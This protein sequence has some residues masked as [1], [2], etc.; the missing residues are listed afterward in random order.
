MHLG[1]ER[2]KLQSWKRARTLP[3]SCPTPN[4]LCGERETAGK[5]RPSWIPRTVPT[6]HRKAPKQLQE[7][8]RYP[9]GGEL[10]Q[11]ARNR[12]CGE[13][14]NFQHFYSSWLISG[15]RWRQGKPELAQ[16]H[17]GVTSCHVYEFDL[18]RRSG[19]AVLWMYISLRFAGQKWR[20]SAF[21]KPRR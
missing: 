4:L 19:N 15:S 1:T 7:G 13:R 10:T 21:F 16:R 6:G 8:Y 17:G 18:P 3:S 2:L 20:E 9:K 5:R 14:S 12:V 11:Q